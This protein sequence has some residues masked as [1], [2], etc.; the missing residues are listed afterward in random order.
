MMKIS[1]SISINRCLENKW[2]LHSLS[3]FLFVF[4]SRTDDCHQQVGTLCCDFFSSSS[5]WNT[6]G[7]LK[8]HMCWFFSRLSRLFHRHLWTGNKF[9]EK[10]YCRRKNFYALRLLQVRQTMG[11]GKSK[12]TEKDSPVP[13]L[14]TQ[15]KFEP[16]A[17]P[18][19][20]NQPASL[21]V[22]PTRNSNIQIE[23]PLKSETTQREPSSSK[24][25]RP[26]DQR[27]IKASWLHQNHT[28]ERYKYV[29]LV[30]RSA[31]IESF[32]FRHAD[33]VLP[34]DP[35]NEYLHR[36]RIAIKRWQDDVPESETTK[37]P[38][39]FFDEYI[40]PWRKKTREPISNSRLLRSPVDAGNPIGKRISCSR[41]RWG[42]KYA[43]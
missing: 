1:D 27:P 20:L 5:K 8:R 41:V 35:D 33:P 12:A 3:F 25:R 42:R 31:S 37:T 4:L 29:S 11:S 13:P 22:D 32:D 21:V 6:S 36:R 19:P 10:I 17:R 2:V 34:D 7:L 16:I 43:D 18:R 40:H 38:K 9:E 26:Q 15:T 30:M 28:N 23:P 14:L 39:S 24:L